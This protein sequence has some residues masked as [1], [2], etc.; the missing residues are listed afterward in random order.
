MSGLSVY[1]R[2]IEVAAA[3]IAA[4]LWAYSSWLARA[5]TGAEKGEGERMK[6]PPPELERHRR[7]V[8]L[9]AGF[10]ALAMAAMGFEAIVSW[11]TGA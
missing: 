10:T 6:E 7:W 5:V 8:S 3:V 4:G 2:V 9:A 1:I 11:T